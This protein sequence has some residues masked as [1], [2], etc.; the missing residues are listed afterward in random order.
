MNSHSLP[1]IQPV[2]HDAHGVP[3]VPPGHVDTYDVPGPRYT[4]YPTVPEWSD[5][6]GPR[7][8]VRALERASGSRAP[9]SLYVHIPF[10]WSMCSYCGCNVIVTRNPARADAYLDLLEIEIGRVA[11][12][13]GDRRDVA[14]LHL[15]GGTPT[16]LDPRQLERLFGILRAHFVLTDDAEATAEINPA[17]TSRAHLEALHRLGINR[18]SF[19]V[20]DFDGQVQESIGRIQTFEETRT[21]LDFARGLGYRSVNFDLIYGLPHQTPRSWARTLDR[22]IELA[23]DRLAIYGF[24]YVP[25]FKP[26]QRKLPA[27]AMPGGPERLDLFRQAWKALSHAGYTSIGMDHFAAPHDPLA[28]AAAEGTLWRN[29]QGYTVQKASETVAFGVSAISDVGGVFAQSPRRMSAYREM[30]LAGRLPIA[31]GLELTAEDHTRRR[32]I[33]QLMC[34]LSLDLGPGATETYADE[35]DALMPLATDGLVD[36]VTADDGSMRVRV[37][38]LGRLFL[39]NIAMPFDA[40]LRSRP[41][42]GRARF[43]RTV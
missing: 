35:F 25:G 4:S 10:C 15:G 23:P 33:T 18:L 20:Q 38:S 30:L 12:H 11:R 5:G 9:L 3:D 37:T 19:G 27:D 36:L 6:F 17:V 26:H 42:D 16:F 41:A 43:S 28:R 7:E 13:L 1:V 31:R 29:F 2:V 34:N 40:R 21:M 14:Q 22:V 39:R 24:A 32:L 8:Y